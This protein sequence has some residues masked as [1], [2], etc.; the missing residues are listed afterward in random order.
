MI[1]QDPIYADL[2]DMGLC[3]S[4]NDWAETTCDKGNWNLVVG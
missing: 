3:L 1:G 2:H 4:R